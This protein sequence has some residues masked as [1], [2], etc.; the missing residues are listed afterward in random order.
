[1]SERHRIEGLGT[2]QLRADGVLHTVFDI[3]EQP[4]IELSSTYLDTRA[5]LVGDAKVPVVIEI[6]H[7]PYTDRDVRSFFMNSLNPA[8]CRAV[9]TTEPSY[10]TIFKTFH[11]LDPHDT[12]TEFFLR[13]DDALA[14]VHEQAASTTDEQ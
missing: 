8:T 4:S 10:E 14:W 2:V 12:P 9:V 1:M 6:R 13:L 3:P 5:E 7:L 11:Q